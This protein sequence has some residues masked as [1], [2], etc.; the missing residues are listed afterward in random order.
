MSDK[1]PTTMAGAAADAAGRLI[2]ALPAQFIVLLILNALF[3][4]C[5]LWFETHSQEQRIAMMNRVLDGCMERL[6][7]KKAP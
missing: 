7:A 4:G 5:I 3:L 2:S 6:E 1:P